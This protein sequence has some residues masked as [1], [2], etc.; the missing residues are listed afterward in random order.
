MAENKKFPRIADD[1]GNGIRAGYYIERGKKF[2]YCEKHDG[3]IE[4]L[5]RLLPEFNRISD[6]DLMEFAY[7]EGIY[8]Y[9]EWDEDDIND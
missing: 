1:T 9:T 4:E 8:Y 3:L 2:Q 7:S 6:K 5:R